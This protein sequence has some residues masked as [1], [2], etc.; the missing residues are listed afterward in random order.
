MKKLTN[1]NIREEIHLGSA[2]YINVNSSTI[3]RLMDDFTIFTEEGPIRMTANIK[4]D[5]GEIPENY[6]EV[7]LN[8]LT[9][10]YNNRVDFGKN[11]FSQ[12]KPVV[13]RKWWQFWKN[14]YFTP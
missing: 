2:N 10:K 9:S 4:V 6:H 14:N 13:K 3:V 11:P 8:V 12:C 5:F 1:K 7:C